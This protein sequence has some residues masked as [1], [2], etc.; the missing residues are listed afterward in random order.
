MKRKQR[1][2]DLYKT[3]QEKE[4]RIPDI[5]DRMEEI[6]LAVN[7]NVKSKTKQNKQIKNQPNN[8]NKNKTRKSKGR[9]RNPD[10]KHR[11]YFQ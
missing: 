7:Q 5:T 6:D 1:S 9:R 8:N 10:Q 3:V 11:K 4:E 2:N